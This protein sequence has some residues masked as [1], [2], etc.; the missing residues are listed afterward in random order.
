MRTGEDPLGSSF[1]MVQ[2]EDVRPP[3]GARQALP[4]Y[5]SS[6]HQLVK[7]ALKRSLDAEVTMHL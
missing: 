1:A 6:Q 3:A 4:T 5:P 2:F 7:A